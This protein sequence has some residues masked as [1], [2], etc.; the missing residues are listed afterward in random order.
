[1]AASVVAN[2]VQQ[3]GEAEMVPVEVWLLR[4]DLWGNSLCS[5]PDGRERRQFGRPPQP[6]NGSFVE[7]G[8]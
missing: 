6:A 4:S 5:E 1:M 2:G 3:R 8:S 7:C